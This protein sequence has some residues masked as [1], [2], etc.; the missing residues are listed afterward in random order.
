MKANIARKEAS[1]GLSLELLLLHHID[2]PP[3]PP[4]QKKQKKK[5]ELLPFDVGCRC[6]L[7]ISFTIFISFVP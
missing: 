6:Q 1:E 7:F 4:G 2:V 5:K 3:S